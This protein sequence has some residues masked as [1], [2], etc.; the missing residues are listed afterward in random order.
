LPLALANRTYLNF[1]G[2]L[3][4]NSPHCCQ[5]WRQIRLKPRFFANIIRWL[6]PTAIEKKDSLIYNYIFF[7][8]EPT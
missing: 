5:A 1:K 6:K 4:K 3:A 7:K 8:S 2:A